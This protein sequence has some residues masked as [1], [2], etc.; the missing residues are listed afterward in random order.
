MFPTVCLGMETGDTLGSFDS[1]F[2]ENHGGMLQGIGLSDK[3]FA[4]REL[5]KIK[6]IHS[7]GKM[8]FDQLETKSQTTL[9]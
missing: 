5:K 9:Y 8:E 7:R 1:T 6:E 2:R 3:L 4:P